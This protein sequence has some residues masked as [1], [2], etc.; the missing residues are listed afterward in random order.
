MSKK[1]KY[2]AEKRGSDKYLNAKHP[3]KMKSSHN[4]ITCRVCMKYT[5]YTRRLQI[6]HFNK[7]K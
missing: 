7:T 4:Y 3:C 5:G 6:E 2:F 1:Y